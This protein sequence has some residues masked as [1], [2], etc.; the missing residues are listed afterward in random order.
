M[1]LC[2]YYV[3]NPIQAAAHMTQ[4]GYIPERLHTH[5]RRPFEI[6]VPKWDIIKCIWR[7]A[8]HAPCWCTISFWLDIWLGLPN[9][10]FLRSTS[11]GRT[12]CTSSSFDTSCIL[13]FDCIPSLEPTTQFRYMPVASQTLAKCLHGHD[14]RSLCVPWCRCSWCWCRTRCRFTTILLQP[15]SMFT[16]T[17]QLRIKFWRHSFLLCVKSFFLSVS[18]V[19]E[20]C[21]LH[22]SSWEAN[23][24]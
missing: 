22:V 19:I 2:V 20:S 10:D 15:K 23:L 11:A 1:L 9:H 4:G 3:T 5:E 7:C 16:A 12:T 6:H 8:N 24:W 14:S 17:F 18:N 13:K 21:L